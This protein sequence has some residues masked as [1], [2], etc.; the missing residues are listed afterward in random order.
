LAKSPAACEHWH[1]STGLCGASSRDTLNNVS[2]WARKNFGFGKSQDNPATL[3]DAYVGLE[4]LNKAAREKVGNDKVDFAL[5]KVNSGIDGTQLVLER[6][7]FGDKIKD[8][9]ENARRLV[10]QARE[11]LE[12]LRQIFSSTQ[13][14]AEDVTE[15]VDKTKKALD[16]LSSALPSANPESQN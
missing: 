10:D 6:E 16:A 9:P 13:R 4:V 1:I 8:I 12:K 2:I 7:G 15:A 3:K 11:E 5:N 14:K